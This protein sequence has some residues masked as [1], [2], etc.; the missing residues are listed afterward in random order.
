MDRDNLRHRN[1]HHG[2]LPKVPTSDKDGET[3]TS[4]IRPPLA[5]LLRRRS[6]RKA[7]MP[8]SLRDRKEAERITT[9]L[10]S[11]GGGKAPEWL[12]MF[13]EK[14]IPTLSGAVNTVGPYVI[15]GVQHGA[16]V[17]CA[18]PKNVLSM[19]YGLTLCFFG[20]MF[21]L[22]LAASEAFYATGGDTVQAAIA[23]LS[24]DLKE[25]KKANDEVCVSFALCMLWL[26]ICPL[27]AVHHYIIPRMTR[28]MKTKMVL[29]MWNRWIHRLC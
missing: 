12:N 1:V 17:Y 7:S 28:E 24:E 4:S 25:L 9:L 18:M 3:R 2:D 26:F 20:G 15:L 14:V 27:R 11:S 29:P 13:I 23:D 21:P 16:D 19:A 22:T 5:S 10:S 8:S 6:S